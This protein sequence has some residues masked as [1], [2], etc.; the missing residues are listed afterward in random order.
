METAIQYQIERLKWFYW[1]SVPRLCDH[2]GKPFIGGH[3]TDLY[4]HHQP[5]AF[6]EIADAFLETHKLPTTFD[7]CYRTNTIKFKRK[8]RDYMMQ[9]QDY[10]QHHANIIIVHDNCYKIINA[11]TKIENT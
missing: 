9:W 11:N 3:P 1:N 5:P 8:D 4:G 2:C 10:H 7:I 6:R